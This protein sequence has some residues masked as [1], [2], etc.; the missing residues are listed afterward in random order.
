MKSHHRP[1]IYESSDFKLMCALARW[2]RQQ[3]GVLFVWHV[4]RLVDWKNNLH[5][6]K[7][8]FPVNYA[9]F[10][11]LWFNYY[12]EFIGFVI[13]EEFDDQFDILVLEYN[14]PLSRDAH[15]G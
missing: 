1:F 13:S 7:R 10:A 11:H 8:R 6:F 5:N 2:Q 14:D 4:A 12:D 9:E 15:V 3:E